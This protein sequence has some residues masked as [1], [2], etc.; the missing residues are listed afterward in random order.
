MEVKYVSSRKSD[1]VDDEIEKKNA[2]NTGWKRE[3]LE[4]FL[5]CGTL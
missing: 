3:V 1:D 2:R 4:F 5:L